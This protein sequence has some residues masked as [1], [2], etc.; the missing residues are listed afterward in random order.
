[1]G[2]DTIHFLQ[3]DNELAEYELFHENG[4]A[5]KMRLLED[6]LDYWGQINYFKRLK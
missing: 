6:N 3:T 4:D 1:M 2:W 5:L